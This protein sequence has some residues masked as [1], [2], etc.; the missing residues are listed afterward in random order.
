MTIT[1]FTPTYNRAHTILRLYNSLLRQTYK[2]FEWLVI[3]DG[4]TDDTGNLFRELIFEHKLN[5]RYYKVEN[6]GKHRAINK[7]LNLA[8]GDIFFI[9]DSD[10]YL[11][12]NALERIVYWFDTIESENEK[13][14]FAGVSGLKGKPTGQLVGTTFQ[15]D[16]K[17]ARYAER[18]KYKIFGDKAE[19][20]YTDIIRKYRFPEFEGENHVAMSVVWAA[21]GGDG[22]KLRYFNEVIYIC[23]YLQD[24]ITKSS[25]SRRRKNI[26]G[27]LY[28]YSKLMRYDFPISLKLRYLLNY[29]RFLLY[30]YVDLTKKRFG[31]N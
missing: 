5:I 1:V 4:S 30:K 8:D 21:I 19:A 11:V 20:Y 24:G 18:I 25:L 3:D 7:A 22:Y 14:N 15:G 6:G 16:Y 13:R 23:E 2:D 17:D 28:A 29:L 26:K 9:V 31:G 12:D 10:D 27:T